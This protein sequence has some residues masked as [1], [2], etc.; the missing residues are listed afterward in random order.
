MKILSVKTILRGVSAF[1][2]CASLSL[3]TALAYA[4]DPELA[5]TAAD[6]RT[7]ASATVQNTSAIAASAP[8]AT[9]VASNRIEQIKSGD[10][11][12]RTV[13]KSAELAADASIQ[14]NFKDLGS[15]RLSFYCPCAQCCG[16]SFSGKTKMG[17]TVTEGRTIAVDSSIIPLGSRVYIDGYGVFVAE[18][19]GGAIKGNKIDIA[20]SEHDQAYALGI[21]TADVYLIG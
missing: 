20:V 1:A 18:D 2:L 7:T 4:G 12:P 14:Q 15:F 21:D 3:G 11:V 5:F 19:I 10:I 8:V 9:A 16:E 17:T 6:P 13:A